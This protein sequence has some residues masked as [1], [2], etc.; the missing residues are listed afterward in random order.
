VWNPGEL[1]G[2]ERLANPRADEALS[3]TRPEYEALRRET[4]V[5]TDAFAMLL[6]GS[7]RVEGRPVTSVLVTGN[8]FQALGVQAALGRPLTPGDDERFAGRPVIVLSHM[9]WTKLFARNPNVIGRQVLVNSV[10]CEIVGVMP[11]GFRGLLI[12]RHT[13][14][15]LSRSPSSSTP[16][17]QAERTRSPLTSSGG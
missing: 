6:G 17:M 7:T 9:G 1:F 11:D 5:F 13:I 10:L 14:G 3:F 12:G 2:V 4:G 16:V 8:F 15:R